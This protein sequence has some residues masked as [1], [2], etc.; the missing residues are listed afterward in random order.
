MCVIKVVLVK[1]STVLSS[2]IYRVYKL[3]QN[4]IF[5]FET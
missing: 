5:N 1:K 2:L 3:E 4:K